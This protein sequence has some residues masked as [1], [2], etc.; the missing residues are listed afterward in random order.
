MSALTG[1]PG[2]S[3]NPVTAPIHQKGTDS[4]NTNAKYVSGDLLRE[5][6][7]CKESTRSGSGRGGAEAP[8]HG[9]PQPKKECAHDDL[10]DHE[11]RLGLG[12]RGGDQCRDLAEQPLA[13]EIMTAPGAVEPNLPL[14]QAA[15]LAGWRGAV[16][17]L[18]V[19]DPAVGLAV[20]DRP[21]TGMAGPFHVYR[22]AM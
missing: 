10:R 17:L 12:R 14:R 21:G 3:C 20:P 22:I 5:T 1:S 18:R 9:D 6:T 13:R 16:A 4:A 15:C 19:L 2:T 8:D 7:V 11:G